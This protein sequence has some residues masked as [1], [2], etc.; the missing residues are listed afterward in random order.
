MWTVT[1]DPEKEIQIEWVV[2]NED[3]EAIAVCPSE[4][5]AKLIADLLNGRPTILPR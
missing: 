4:D 1:H 3:M 5:T 2:H